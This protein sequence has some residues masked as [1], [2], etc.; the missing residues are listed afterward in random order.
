MGNETVALALAASLQSEQRRSWECVLN[1]LEGSAIEEVKEKLKDR[2]LGTGTPRILF[3]FL[4]YLLWR[5]GLVSTNEEDE[6]RRKN[7]QFAYWNSV[8]HWYPQTP[9]DSMHDDW[10]K[11]DPS[12]DTFGNLFY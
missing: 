11:Q 8:E 6:K 12:V 7:F 10:P 3:N 2:N 5:D 9:D 4:N 1:L